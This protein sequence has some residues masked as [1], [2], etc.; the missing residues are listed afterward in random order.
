MRGNWAPS[1][2][3]L[4]GHNEND[5]EMS[6]KCTEVLKWPYTTASSNELIKTL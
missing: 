2:G 4:V 3:N 6:I 5:S 1:C